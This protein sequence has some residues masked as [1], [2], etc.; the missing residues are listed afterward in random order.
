M[1]ASSVSGHRLKKVQLTAAPTSRTLP[2]CLAMNDRLAKYCACGERW[3][4][5][6]NG[7]RICPTVNRSPFFGRSRT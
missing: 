3:A 7:T 5:I 4:S 1:P 6:V 2:T